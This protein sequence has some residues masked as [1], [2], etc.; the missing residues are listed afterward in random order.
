MQDPSLKRC[1]G[2]DKRISEC[3]WDYLS[4]LQSVREPKQPLPR[5]SDLL[6]WLAAP[7]REEIWLLLDI[8]VRSHANISSLGP[9]KSIPFRSTPFSCPPP[10]IFTHAGGLGSGG[11]VS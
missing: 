1:Y 3:N 11:G 2:V 10:F 6:E 5:L 9:V 8:K 7:G 4:S